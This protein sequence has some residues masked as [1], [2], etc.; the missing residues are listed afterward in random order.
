MHD[1]FPGPLLLTNGSISVVLWRLFVMFHVTLI[2]VK[3][4]LPEGLCKPT[5]DENRYADNTKTTNLEFKM[6]AN[7]WIKFENC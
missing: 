7:G 6:Q 2:E 3:I 1:E 5:T 4:V